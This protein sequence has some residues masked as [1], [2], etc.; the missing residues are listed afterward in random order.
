MSLRHVLEELA[1][2]GSMVKK[3]QRKTWLPA[4]QCL[5]DLRNVLEEPLDVGPT[6]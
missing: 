1:N 4:E 3:H 5:M 6:T 2:V